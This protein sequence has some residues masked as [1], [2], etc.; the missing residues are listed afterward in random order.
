MNNAIIYL[1]GYAGCGKRTIAQAIRQRFDAVLVDN[2]LIN[3]TIF[4]LIEADGKT[5]L[6]E[7]V[8]N[9]VIAV[10]HAALATIRDV[11]PGLGIILTWTLHLL[12]RTQQRWT[13]LWR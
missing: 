3:N 13:S 11:A 6:P 10:R 2:H 1:L 4:S 8:W 7:G 5:P 12:H 9:H